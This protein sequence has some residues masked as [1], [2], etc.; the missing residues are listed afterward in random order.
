MIVVYNGEG[1]CNI[2]WP[3]PIEDFIPGVPRDVPDEI[4]QA[5]L[6]RGDFSE[7]TEQPPVP[8]AE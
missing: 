1:R 6:A 3:E 7:T 5:C 4:G 8:P 2:G